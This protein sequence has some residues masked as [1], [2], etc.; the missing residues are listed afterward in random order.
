VTE[1]FD[2]DGHL[3]LRS[4]PAGAALTLAWD[5][6]EPTWIEGPAGRRISFGEAQVTERRRVRVAT[7]PAGM[8]ARYE[9]D[10]DGRLTA[11]TGADGARRRYHYGE[12]GALQAVLWSDGSSLEVHRDEAGRVTDLQGPGAR[13][14]RYEWGDDGLQRAWDDRGLPWRVQRRADEIAVTDPAGRTASLLLGPAG[15]AGWRDPAGHSTL[16]SRDEAGRPVLLQTAA[17]E[18]W[19]LAWDPAGRI[20]QVTDP[21]GGRWRLVRDGGGQSL[22][23]VDPLGRSRLF[24]FDEAGR[25]GE[26]SDGL[27]VRRL[28]RDAAGLVHQIVEGVGGITRI[29]RDAAGRVG[30]IVDA[31]GTRTRLEAFVGT[32]PGRITDAGGGVWKLAFDLLGRIAGLDAPDGSHSDW[33]R[34]PGGLLAAVRR[35]RAQTHFGRRQDGAI[36]RLIDPLG[37]VTGWA[38]DAT[39]RPRAVFQ[40]DGSRL[41]ITRDARGAIRALSMG[42]R[43]QEVRRDALGRP[44][45]VGPGDPEGAPPGLTWHRDPCGRI[46]RVAWP[47]G[48]LTLTRDTAGLVRTVDLAGEVWALERDLAGRLV[49]V[50]HGDR[51]WKLRRDDSGRVVELQG[52]EVGVAVEPDPRGLARRV[53]TLGLRVGWRRDGAGRPVQIEGPGGV[54]LGIQRDDS[55]RPRLLRLPDGLLLKRAQDGDDVRLTLEDGTGALLF[56]TSLGHDALGRPTSGAGDGGARQHRYGPLGE[57]QSIEQAEG[58]WTVFPDRREGPAGTVTVQTDADGQPGEVRLDGSTPAWG[59]G[60]QTLRWVGAGSGGLA[61]VEGEGGRAE[62]VHDPIGRL[63]AVHVLGPSGDAPLASFSLHWDPFGRPEAIEAPGGSTLLTYHEGALLGMREGARSV[64][65]L[66]GGLGL[67]VAADAAGHGLLWSP[68]GAGFE[69]AWSAP[70]TRRLDHPSPGGLRDPAMPGGLG[71]QGRLQLFPGGPLVGPEDALDPLTGLPTAHAPGRLAWSDPGW[72]DPTTPVRWPEPDGAAQVPWDPARWG[73]AAP[74]D[75]PLGLA[76]ALGALDPVIPGPWWTPGAATAPLPWLPAD[77]EGRPPRLLPPPDALP[78]AEEPLTARFLQAALIPRAAPEVEEILHLLLA[79]DL[80]RV[81]APLPGTTSG[82]PLPHAP[83]G[84]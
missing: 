13:R 1:R 33:T 50:V 29:E 10:D 66:D 34:T 64:L 56:A 62:L 27:V 12:D 81:P 75:D 82:E 39:E 59:V 37:R 77:F 55:G 78:L 40:A 60:R 23:I 30:A 45:E 80:A 51:A 14:W 70:L 18:R 47:S 17:Q 41:D 52:P 24:A 46:E 5:Q 69:L 68:A 11:V 28:I 65:L 36:T 16:L 53:E 35:D 3:L 38:L 84:F 48:A 26:I 32:S 44:I 67:Q 76:V 71:L 9:W 15:I 8:Q 2:L 6:G 20:V 73:T 7:G 74:W 4:T 49:R 61:A 57:L 58:A 83:R 22:R 79:E 25:V 21:G 54:T 63:V 19:S 31:A 72:P 42:D 43:R